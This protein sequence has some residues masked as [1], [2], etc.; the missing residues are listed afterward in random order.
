MRK[1]R[2]E[3]MANKSASIRK[4]REERK[5]VYVALFKKMFVKTKLIL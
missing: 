1:Q 4:I 2:L 5:R 3:A